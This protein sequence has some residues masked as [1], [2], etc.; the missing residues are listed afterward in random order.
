V[1][2]RELLILALAALVIGA[3]VA[4]ASAG[5]PC[6]NPSSTEEVSDTNEASDTLET[7]VKEEAEPDLAADRVSLAAR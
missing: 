6:R 2:I 3:T 7:E 1:R 4:S 5:A